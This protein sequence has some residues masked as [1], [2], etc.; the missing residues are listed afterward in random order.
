MEALQE[1]GC[2]DAKDTCELTIRMASDGQAP[3]QNC[4][5]I[6]VERVME[7]TEIEQEPPAII[8]NN[9]PPQNWPEM[10]KKQP[11]LYL[12]WV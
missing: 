1:I 9:R 11:I 6:S 8:E 10:N 7:Y 5:Q 2:F 3:C 4:L 12:S